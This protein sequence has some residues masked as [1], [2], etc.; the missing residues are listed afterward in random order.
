MKYLIFIITSMLIHLTVNAQNMDEWHDGSAIELKG[1]I[2]IL[3]VFIT[4]PGKTWTY[5]EKT[6]LLTSQ[7]KAQDWLKQQAKLYGA[8]ISFENGFY[9]LK[10]DIVVDEIKSIKELYEARQDWVYQVL[11]KIGY[12]S[13]LEFLERLKNTKDCANALVIIYANQSGR[14]YAVPYSTGRNKEKYFFEGCTVYRKDTYYQYTCGATIAHEILHLF[15]AWDL[16]KRDKTDKERAKKADA[17]FHNDIMIGG[18]CDLE[19]LKITRLTAW[20]V[21]LWKYKEDV[22]EELRP[23]NH[24]SE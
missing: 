4:T 15:G 10:S 23:R 16:Y 7:F 14:S 5:D 17:L 1:K 22:F 6:D 24:P 13:P 21:G 19:S 20:L 11:T 12:S 8:D 3:S 9:G 2:Y 18:T